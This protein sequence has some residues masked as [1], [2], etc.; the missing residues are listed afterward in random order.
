ML[1]KI[2]LSI[3]LIA[4]I[5]YLSLWAWAVHWIDEDK[6]IVDF[7]SED[8]N[9]ILLIAKTGWAF[10]PAIDREKDAQRLLKI[11]ELS[12]YTGLK[13][14]ISNLKTNYNFISYYYEENKNALSDELKSKFI[15]Q[16]LILM[17]RSLMQIKDEQFEKEIASMIEN[18]SYYGKDNLETRIEWLPEFI[19]F[20]FWHQNTIYDEINLYKNTL[21]K[22]NNYF[23]EN[24]KYMEDKYN[25]DS[26][27][28]IYL[29]HN[30]LSFGCYNRHLYQNKK[31][32]EKTLLR[33]DK[34]GKDT[35][36][37]IQQRITPRS[38]EYKVINELM[39]KNDNYLIIFPVIFFD[40]NSECRKEAMNFL[41]KMNEI[42]SILD[43]ENVVSKSL[44]SNLLSKQVF[45]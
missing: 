29:Y 23:L 7:V 3:C 25:T 11:I 30:A 22:Y 16:K 35:F 14:N 5:A 21:E 9:I 2:F 13:N 37:I 44:R 18:N 26:F 27:D 42:A 43:K 20:I 28:V 24:L 36:E 12:S 19:W 10:T 41:S 33:A 34:F 45:D 1:K 4:V 6:N 17:N 38:K 39:M 31:S 32:I 40:S 8:E 15:L